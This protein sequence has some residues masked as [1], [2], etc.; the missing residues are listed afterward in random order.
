MPNNP[1]ENI[2]EVLGENEPT[3]LLGI[4]VAAT[5]FSTGEYVN[6]LGQTKVGPST[7]LMLLDSDVNLTVGEGSAVT[8]GT[9]CGT[10]KRARS[11]R[12]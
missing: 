11:N 9:M 6:S 3:E 12:L 7:T 2:T 10:L 4:N 8:L 1:N 5:G